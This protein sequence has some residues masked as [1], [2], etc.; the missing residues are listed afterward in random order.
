VNHEN[1]GIM[2]E[3]PRFGRVTVMWDAFDRIEFS[4]PGSS[5]RSYGEFPPL[6]RIAGAVTTR[7]GDVHRGYLVIDLDEAYG[8]EIIN[9]SDRD[10][11]YDIPL[12]LIREIH[13]EGDDESLIVLRGGESVHLFDGQDVTDKNAGVIIFLGENNRDPQY[14]PWDEV[15]KIVLD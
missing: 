9:G 14:V 15:D 6:G 10:I 13:R 11:E 12:A 7:D 8:W 2:I 5:G 4:E 1:R 3:D